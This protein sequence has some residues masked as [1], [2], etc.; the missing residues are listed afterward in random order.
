[1]VRRSLM[2]DLQWVRCVSFC[3]IAVKPAEI[4]IIIIIKFI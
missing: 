3:D 2:M 1:L 4:I